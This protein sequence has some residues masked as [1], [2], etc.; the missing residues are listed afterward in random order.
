MQ[1]TEADDPAVDDLRRVGTVGVIRQMSK[2]PN[3]LQVLVE[4]IVRVR[5][6]SYHR[7][8]DVL[9]ASIALHPE[10]PDRGIEVDAY[11]RRVRE[12]MD[13]AV[14]LASGISPDLRQLLMSVEDPLRLVY[15][16]GTLLDMKPED[17]QLLLEHDEVTAKLNA[18]S[19]RCSA[20][21]PCWS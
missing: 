18:V 11:V 20:R 21:S 16:L 13:K 5:V 10:S 15:I 1:Q 8:G 4:G 9:Q 12:Q 3:G 7:E 14:S 6:E 19:R 2:A 17:K